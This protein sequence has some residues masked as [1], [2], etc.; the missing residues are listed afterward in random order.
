M[1][2]LSQEL[3]PCVGCYPVAAN[4]YVTHF[5]QLW[6]TLITIGWVQCQIRDVS[7]GISLFAVSLSV[8]EPLITCMHPFVT[9]RCLT[10]RLHIYFGAHIFVTA[11][12]RLLSNFC[13]PYIRLSQ[14]SEDHFFLP[15]KAPIINK[16]KQMPGGDKTMI[17]LALTVC[18]HSCLNRD[19]VF[20]VIL[21]DFQHFHTSSFSFVLCFNS[22][23]GIILSRRVSQIQV[24]V[25]A[26]IP[27]LHVHCNCLP[28]PF[29]WFWPGSY[30]KI[31][32][33]EEMA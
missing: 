7:L 22:T 33:R 17:N 20:L 19:H 29:F 24:T 28:E 5:V 32:S 6:Y 10:G 31:K 30:I 15:S 23:Y 12:V 18:V 25:D 16:Y 11:V 13:L 2:S 26:Q 3:K 1:L 27:C 9:N 14:V 21:V 4:S 8:S